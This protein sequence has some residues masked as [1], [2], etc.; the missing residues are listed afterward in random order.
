[1]ATT[2]QNPFDTQQAKPAGIVASAL[3]QSGQ[4]MTYTP[5]TRQVNQP[6]ETVQGQVNSILTKDSPLMQRART[7]ATQGMAQRGLVNSSMAQGAGTAAMI[8]RAL[9]MAQQ[10]AQTYG[11]VSQDNMNA[12]NSA[13]Q[14]GAG[15]LN[16]FG[17]QKGEQDFSAQQSALNRGFQTS[18]RLGSQD[19]TSNFEVAKQNFTSAQAALDRAQQ[20]ALTDKSIQAQQALQNAQQAFQGAQASLDR[21]Q[22]TNLQNSQQGFQA[23]Q[24]II[25]NDFNKQ[26][27]TLQESGMD[28]RQARDIASRDALARLEQMGVQNRFDQEI[29]LKSEMFNVEQYNSERRMIMQNQ[30]EFDKLG[31]QIKANTAQIPSNFAAT[32]SSNAMNGVN[33]VMA[34]GAL[35]AAGKKAA[36]DNIV[37]YA[38][39]QIAWGAKF[40][41]TAIPA[42]GTPT[43]PT[44]TVYNPAA[45]SATAP[46]TSGQSTMTGGPALLQ[47]VAR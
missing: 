17:L 12:R 19:F 16:Q 40:Y 38:N 35:D 43:S 41:G 8:D 15:Q 27:Q 42:F 31:L 7:L 13:A 2:V 20:V 47:N 21:T 4:A 26:M 23:S 5:E 28:F 22:Q 6:T 18:E 9:P 44:T 37:G 33:A 24:Q 36:I 45:P 25:Q 32:I 39:A 10:D 46:V 14:F 1:M 29:A 30:A 11:Q 34:D 3:P